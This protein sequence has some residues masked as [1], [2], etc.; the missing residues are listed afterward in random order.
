MDAAI[1]RLKGALWNPGLEGANLG[2]AGSNACIQSLSNLAVVMAIANNDKVK[3]LFSASN[4]RIYA[5]FKGIDNLINAQEACGNPIKGANGDLKA[6]W[7]DAYSTWITD[8]VKS[9]NDL[10]T[11]TASQISAAISTDVN[12]APDNKKGNVRNW[13]VFVSNFNA[14]YTVNSLTFPQ[15]TVWPSDGLGIQRRAI[16]TE[17]AACSIRRHSASAGSTTKSESSSTSAGS[18]SKSA[19]HVTSGGSTTKMNP[20][21][22]ITQPPISSQILPP[23]TSPRF[24]C[25]SSE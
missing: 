24:T 20:F 7:A 5:A 2:C 8:K 22:T 12:A 11:K 9:N 21:S 4:G 14:A 19:S 15:P 18:T 17:G 23:Y 25:T 16:A 6:T 3:E 13:S 1:N 10:I